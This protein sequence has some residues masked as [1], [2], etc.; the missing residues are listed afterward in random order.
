MEFLLSV[1]HD[2]SRIGAA[3]EWDNESNTS[4]QVFNYINT[5]R[6]KSASLINEKKVTE[7][8]ERRVTY[9][10]QIGDLKHNG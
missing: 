2:I 8:R 5:W 3:N 9:Q 1:Q 7:W 6:E 10:H 4:N